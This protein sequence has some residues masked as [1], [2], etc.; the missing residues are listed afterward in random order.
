MLNAIGLQFKK[1]SGLLGRLVSFIMLKWN[2]TAYENA[3][4]E[5][6]IKTQDTI[7][8]IGYGPGFGINLISRQLKPKMVYGIDF[9]ELMFRRATKLNLPFIRDGKVKLYFDDF[10]KMQVENNFV[11]KIFCI[12]VVY[13]WNN[14]EIPFKKAY[15]M[16]KNGGRFCIFSVKTDDL[17][18]L[19]YTK[20]T[21][22]NKRTIEEIIEKLRLV[23]FKQI[24]YHYDNGYFI[25]ARK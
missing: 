5:L 14:L 21:I 22:F 11:D 8:E 15:S 16:L 10:I 2:K 18:K 23:G 13:F 7:F 17:N 12:N 20:D 6:E 24:D 25:K 19:K 4:N 9:S 1:P 3:I